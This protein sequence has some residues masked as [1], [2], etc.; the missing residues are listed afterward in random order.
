[1][2][3]WVHH[4]PEANLIST[5]IRYWSD[6]FALDRCLIE[7]DA[8]ILTMLD[9]CVSGGWLWM[10]GITSP[11]CGMDCWGCWSPWWSVLW[12][13]CLQ[14]T[15]SIINLIHRVNIQLFC[16]QHICAYD[17]ALTWHT[18]EPDGPSSLLNIY[19]LFLV[20]LWIILKAMSHAQFERYVENKIPPAPR[21]NQFR[22][23][24]Q[25][26]WMFALH[27]YGLSNSSF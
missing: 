3:C 1:M 19:S 4:S 15:N 10:I 12:P 8:W 11:T 27:R 14:V 22:Q 17:C 20:N 24:Y 7:V 13:V 2:A 21:V 5:Y 9:P 18:S 25:M 23:W 26:V 16:I 6:T